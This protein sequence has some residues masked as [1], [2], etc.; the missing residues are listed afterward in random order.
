MML[1]LNATLPD[2]QSQPGRRD[3]RTAKKSAAAK[4]IAAAP[5]FPRRNYGVAVGVG[6]AVAV[7]VVPGVAVG[8]GLGEP[9]GVGVGDCE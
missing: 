9:P 6:V 4:W 1:L 5:Q 3:C 8:L 7:G 2:R